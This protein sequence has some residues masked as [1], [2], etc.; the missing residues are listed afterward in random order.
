MFLKSI[1]CLRQPPSSLKAALPTNID[2]KVSNRGSGLCRRRIAEHLQQS[3]TFSCQLDFLNLCRWG[4][5]CLTFLRFGLWRSCLCASV[6]AYVCPHCMFM[7]ELCACGCV[8]V[9][10]TVRTQSRIVSVFGW[11]GS[12]CRSTTGCST[13]KN[14]Y[15][16]SVRFSVVSSLQVSVSECFSSLFRFK[17]SQ[18]FVVSREK[19]LQTHRT[20]LT[21]TAF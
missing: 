16:I 10:F 15:E 1:F 5:E 19:A 21:D 14:D 17:R 9:F 11:I 6:R 2:F 4:I 13:T 8:W 3:P 12:A 20:Q 7:S 18:R